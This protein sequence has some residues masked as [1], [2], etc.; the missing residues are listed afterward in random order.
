[1]RAFGVGSFGEAERSYQKLIYW[2]EA[3]KR[4]HLLREEHTPV[5]L[6]TSQKH[7]GG[8]QWVSNRKLP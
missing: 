8:L 4:G 1:M 2:H 6:T 3:E 7:K 5:V